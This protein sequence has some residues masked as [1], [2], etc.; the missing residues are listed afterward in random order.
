M[1]NNY[2]NSRNRCEHSSTYDPHYIDRREINARFA[3]AHSAWPYHS[4]IPQGG[5]GY[6]SIN[7]TAIPLA[8]PVQNIP[9]AFSPSVKIGSSR[10]A[11][12]AGAAKG[13]AKASAAGAKTSGNP[14]DTYP[15]YQA[16]KK[17]ST[18]DKSRLG[19]VKAAVDARGGA[20][21]SPGSNTATRP[22]R[23]VHF[24]ALPGKTKDGDPRLPYDEPP[25]PYT[26]KSAQHNPFW[27]CMPCVSGHGK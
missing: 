5:L 19:R 3:S 24:P 4:A 16:P 15:R 9:Q 2:W 25:P 6:T 1:N 10:G 11:D 12:D 14:T 26:E 23:P 21:L 18:A 13:V 27:S 8:Q 20:R 17:G 22:G 7:S